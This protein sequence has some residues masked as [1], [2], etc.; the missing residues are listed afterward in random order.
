MASAATVAALPVIPACNSGSVSRDRWGSSYQVADLRR[1]KRNWTSRGERWSAAAKLRRVFQTR[2]AGRRGPQRR[3]SGCKPSTA[4]RLTARLAQESRSVP[5]LFANNGRPTAEAQTLQEYPRL[6]TD[7][8]SILCFGHA[9]WPSSNLLRALSAK[10][11]P[12]AVDAGLECKVDLRQKC[13][14]PEAEG[15]ENLLRSF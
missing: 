1:R 12:H 7:G 4:P 9:Q 13:P 3:G 11:R 5:H 15:W 6:R 8:V 2:V 10:T 14:R